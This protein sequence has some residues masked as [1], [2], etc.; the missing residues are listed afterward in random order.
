VPV[1]GGVR[2]VNLYPG[3]D[4]ELTSEGGQ[5]VQRLAAEPGADRSGVRLRVEGTDAVAVAGDALRLSTAVGEFTLPLL[6]TDGLQAAGLNVQPRGEQAFDVDAPFAVPNANAASR[7]ASSPQFAIVN[8]QSV[9]DNPADL[10]YGTFLGGGAYDA[11]NAIAVDGTS[12]AYVTG[13]TEY[14]DSNKHD[15]V[16]RQYE[17]ADFCGRKSLFTSGPAVIHRVMREVDV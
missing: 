3:V 16:D 17:R 9:A 15:R 14:S 8:P 6:R 2:Y 7:D 12:S 5:M 10:L 4:L 11:G 13:A 1:W